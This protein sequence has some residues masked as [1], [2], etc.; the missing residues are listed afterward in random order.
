[1][2]W[3]LSTNPLTILLGN[4]GC[5]GDSSLNGSASW[6]QL[7]LGQVCKYSLRQETVKPG[8]KCQ[9]FVSLTVRQCSKK[10]KL[11]QAISLIHSCQEACALGLRIHDR[12]PK[13]QSRKGPMSLQEFDCFHIL[14]ICLL[15]GPGHS[16]FLAKLGDRFITADSLTSPCFKSKEH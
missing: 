11:V 1:M 12:T 10:L 8:K 4:N 7:V 6:L 16:F 2:T 13:R 5:D 9:L 15:P 14:S 3:R